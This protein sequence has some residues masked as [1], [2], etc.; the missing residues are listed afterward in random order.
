MLKELHRQFPKA[1]IVGLRNLK[2][3]HD[4]PCFDVIEAYKDLKPY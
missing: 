3:G 4:C 1:L 2:P